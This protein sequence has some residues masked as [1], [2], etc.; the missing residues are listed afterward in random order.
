[1]GRLLKSF[2]DPKL[3]RKTTILRAVFLLLS[4]SVVALLVAVASGGELLARGSST[5]G[6]FVSDGH[7]STVLWSDSP[8]IYLLLFFWYALISLSLVAGLYIA[9]ARLLEKLHGRRSR[10]FQRK[11]PH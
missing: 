10:F 2:S 9:L 4:L 1:M 11:Y 5:G 3:A 8:V 6:R 7:L